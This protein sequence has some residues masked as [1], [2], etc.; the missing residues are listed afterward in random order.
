MM[1][2]VNEDGT[3]TKIYDSKELAKAVKDTLNYYEER[4]AAAN[5]R[6]NRTLEEAKQ[7]VTNQYEEENKRLKR[8]LKW[9]WGEFASEKEYDAFMQFR[10]EHMHNRAES[11]ANGGK[12]PYIIPDYTGIGC[13]KDVVCQICGEKRDITDM[14]AW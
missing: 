14:E 1:H 8:R 11:R 2:T 10:Q 6:A 9:S 4:T 7:F 13:A 5:E 12:E 3:F